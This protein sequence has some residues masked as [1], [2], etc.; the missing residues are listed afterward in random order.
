[1]TTP[2]ALAGVQQVGFKPHLRVEVVG[3]EAVYLLSEHGTTA[4]HGPCIE[5]LA[6]LLDGTRTLETVLDEVS[7]VLP[8]EAAAQT[9]AA[10][11]GAELIGYRSP[12]ADCAAE[13]YWEL[14]GLSGAGAQA[15]LRNTPVRVVTLGSVDADTVRR[16]CLASGLTLAATDESA[17]FTLVLC[18]DYLNP[19]LDGVDAAHRG[20][21][22]PWL[23]AKPC[24]VQAWVG[25]VFGRP[26][27]PCWSCLAHRLRGHRVTHVPVQR[28]LGLSGP[29]A[30]PQAYVNSVRSLGLQTAVLEAMKWAA[31]M[32]HAEQ[33]AVCTLDTRTLRTRHH[34]VARRPQCPQCGDPGLTAAR[35]RRPVTFV[36]RLKSGA[37]GGDQR[38]LPPEAVL[39]RYGH[40]VDPLTGVV[41]EVKP[42][43]GAPDGLNRYVS[44]RNPALQAHSLAALRGGLRSHSGGKGITPVEAEVGALCEAVERY[45]ATRH[46]DEPVV[47]DSFTGL[48]ADAVHPNACQLYAERQFARRDAW[49]RTASAFN[50]VPPPFDPGARREWTP[51]WSLTAGAHRMLPTSML[52]FGPAPGAG[53]AAPWAD[54][55]G[56]AAGSSL[57]DAV[58]QGFLEVVERDAV[59]LWWYNR[60]RQPAVDLDAFDEPWLARIRTTYDRLGRE[61]WA[62]D[63]TADLGIP[64]MVAVSRRRARPAER[65][66]FGF[67]AHFD[68]RTAL[69]R[70]VTEMAQLLPPEDTA[71]DPGSGFASLHPELSTWWQEATVENQPYL[72]PDPAESPLTPGSCMWTPRVDLAEE[73]TAAEALV[74]GAGMEML[75]LDQ[76]RPDVELPVVKVVVPGMRSFWARYAPGRLYDVPVQLGRV[77]GPTRYEDLNPIPL[78]V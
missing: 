68:P 67:G 44:G 8:A 75:V 7:A 15:A 77:C 21:G 45:S 78:F 17:V 4:L 65:I 3:G 70:A 76:T 51:V 27:G 50:H 71:A 10:L 47:V 20:A 37:P 60:T 28:V 59:A 12:A 24:G 52:Y 33:G 23:L 2:R 14:S 55:N 36:P 40:L 25:P 57:E 13:A 58:V 32:R 46:G 11:A 19:E 53:P 64:V 49:N 73:I 39:A 38:A 56:N 54:S 16:E 61:L 9:I 42:A 18:D 6:P 62:L 30:L 43:P 5:A 34:A 29:V 1:M 22:R 63:L 31:G 66:C 35:V 48:G 41:P 72:R 69:R 74:R 26:D